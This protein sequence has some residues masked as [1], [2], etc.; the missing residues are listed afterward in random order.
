MGLLSRNGSLGNR[1]MGWYCFTRLY[2]HD[3]ICNCK[4]EEATEKNGGSGQK[5]VV[6]GSRRHN[7]N[8]Q[9]GRYGRRWK[10][11]KLIRKEAQPLP[12]RSAR[13][14]ST[15][16]SDGRSLSSTTRHGRS[17]P[18]TTWN[19]RRCFPLTTR[20]GWRSLPPAA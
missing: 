1:S 8:L 14:R 2:H 19:G 3:C 9:H 13:I 5:H 11:L 15:G 7:D 6:C 17:L 18:L 4:Q 12:Q 20:H 16:A 10:I